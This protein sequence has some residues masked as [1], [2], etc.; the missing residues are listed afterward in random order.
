MSML[1]DFQFMRGEGS[2]ELNGGQSKTRAHK[3][4]PRFA[5]LE[6]KYLRPDF[7]LM[8]CYYEVFQQR[9]RLDLAE[10]EELSKLRA[11]G[12][13]QRFRGRSWRSLLAFYKRRLGLGILSQ[14]GY[15]VVW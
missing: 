14:V 3:S 11:L 9:H 1:K 10:G 6:G 4:L 5:P 2:S 15:S 8:W 7:V 13:R 12:W